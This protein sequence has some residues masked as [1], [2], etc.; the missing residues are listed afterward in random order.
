M[1]SLIH[2]FVCDASNDPDYIMMLMTVLTGALA[3]AQKVLAVTPWTQD[4]LTGHGV[5]TLFPLAVYWLFRKP[6][7]MIPVQLLFLGF[8]IGLLVQL[9]W[10]I[11][12]LRNAKAHKHV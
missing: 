9:G 4:I 8:E 10:R 11:F 5:M 2:N 1:A 6:V 12:R 3:F 7:L